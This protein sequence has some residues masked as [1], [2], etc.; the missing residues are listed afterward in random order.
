MLKNNTH[1]IKHTLLKVIAVLITLCYIMEPAQ[2][3]LRYV[4]H[5]IS[6]NLQAPS[7]VLQH[8]TSISYKDLAKSK[9]SLTNHEHEILDFIDKMVNSSSGN[10]K[11]K[12]TSN[13]NNFTIKKIVVRYNYAFV[14]HD[15]SFDFKNDNFKIIRSLRLKGHSL[16]LYRPPQFLVAS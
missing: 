1:K 12:D 14:K 4:F 15:F 2:K 3:E 5:F 6:H 7:Y 13:T 10:N 16:Q 8:D 11:H 9:N